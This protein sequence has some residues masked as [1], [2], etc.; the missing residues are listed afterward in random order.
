MLLVA[1]SNPLTSTWPDVA[2]KKEVIIFIIVLFPA[3]LGPK[4]PTICP[5]GISKETLSNAHWVPYC[6]LT[7]L[8]IIDIPLA[9]STK[10]NDEDF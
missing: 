1:T 4:K 7:F 6:L 10:V 8:T 5:F 9:V 3:P 2:G